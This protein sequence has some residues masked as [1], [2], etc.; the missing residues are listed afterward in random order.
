MSSVAIIGGS[1]ILSQDFDGKLHSRPGYDMDRDIPW[2]DADWEKW[3]CNALYEAY[4]TDADDS[5][6][7]ARYAI[8][9]YRFDRWFQLHTPQ[10]MRRH[11]SK[12]WPAHE[13]WLRREHRFPIYMQREYGQYP[14]SRRFPKEKVDKLHY[15]GGY[16]IST[17]TWMLAYAVAE[18]FERI[19]L[20]GVDADKG[21]PLAARACLEFWIGYALGRGI[22][23]E[24]ITASPRMFTSVHAAELYSNLQYA[25]DPEPAFELG[26]G[27]RD[28][29]I[30]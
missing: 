4:P 29:R 10:Y 23:I 7:R 12:E 27:W 9:Y 16:Q 14:S 6:D 5:D 24:V 25:Y 1:R 2:D 11:W 19:H 20:F 3:S 21:E 26:D 18:R 15:L 30:R 22:D 28:V 13:I 17:F 8:D